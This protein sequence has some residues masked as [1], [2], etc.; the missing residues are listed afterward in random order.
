MT[1]PKRQLT[2]TQRAAFNAL[3][4]EV[5]RQTFKYGTLDCATFAIRAYEAVT[6]KT[7]PVQV[8]WSNEQEADSTLAEMGGLRAAFTTALGEPAN[9]ATCVRGDILLADIE[10]TVVVGVHDGARMV[11]VAGPEVRGLKQVPWPF[12]LC[13][14]RIV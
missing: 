4:D 8:T 1:E 2:Q 3:L 5:S 14:W 9:L 10:G 13:G 7:S 6:G 11:A 12:V